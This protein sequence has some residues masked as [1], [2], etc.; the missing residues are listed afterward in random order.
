MGESKQGDAA[1]SGDFCRFSS[2]EAR[3]FLS[4]IWWR[5]RM[6][7]IPLSSARDPH[8]VASLSPAHL[9]FRVERKLSVRENDFMTEGG[10]R[11]V[12]I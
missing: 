10:V 2:K 1:N 12:V 9:C 5:M 7:A 4:L 8:K 3:C 11:A 6:T